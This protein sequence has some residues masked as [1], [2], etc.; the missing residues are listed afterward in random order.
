[1]VTHKQ[2]RFFFMSRGL[3]SLLEEEIVR[4]ILETLLITA[5]LS[6]FPVSSV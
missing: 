4:H 1:M 6:T 3:G 5:G 2:L